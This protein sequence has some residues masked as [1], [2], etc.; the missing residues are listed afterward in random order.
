MQCT[1]VAGV[2]RCVCVYACSFWRLKVTVIALLRPARLPQSVSIQSYSVR[3]DA[4]VICECVVAFA[5]ALSV[6]VSPHVISPEFVLIGAY[7]LERQLGKLCPCIFIRKDVCTH[8]H[9]IMCIHEYNVIKMKQF[10]L[11][12]TGHLIF[13]LRE[14]LIFLH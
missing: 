2:F 14:R 10:S 9:K 5:H 7:S 11:H 13:S 6:H 8:T 1:V 4:P 12:L 3:R